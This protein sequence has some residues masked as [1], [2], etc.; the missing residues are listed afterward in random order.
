MILI[1]FIDCDISGLIDTPKCFLKA[2]SHDTTRDDPFNHFHDSF[3]KTI[4]GLR[5]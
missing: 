1:N 5:N 4:Q 3:L 2:L